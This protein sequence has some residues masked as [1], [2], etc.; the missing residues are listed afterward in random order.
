MVWTDYLNL[1]NYWE[2]LKQ[3]DHH[4]AGITPISSWLFY[5]IKGE[6]GNTPALHKEYFIE[7][8]LIQ[9]SA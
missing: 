5:V 7:C 8:S 9:I 4:T 1:P 6:D 3:T 2:K